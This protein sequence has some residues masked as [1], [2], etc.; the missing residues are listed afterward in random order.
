MPRKRPVAS[1]SDSAN[2]A[3][4]TPSSVGGGGNN[5]VDATGRGSSRPRY[6]IETTLDG[7]GAAAHATT[8]ELADTTNASMQTAPNHLTEDHPT[9]N[10]SAGFPRWRRRPFRSPS[11]RCHEPHMCA[12]WYR[13][14]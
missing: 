4:W 3:P 1:S 8:K 5:E 2:R 12:L 13:S 14:A 9:Y 6:K 10:R 11:H 7:A